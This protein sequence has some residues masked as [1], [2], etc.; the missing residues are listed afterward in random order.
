MTHA[1][2]REA[3]RDRGRERGKDETMTPSNH[4]HKNRPT[5]SDRTQQLYNYNPPFY[6][7]T[8]SSP[9]YSSFPKIRIFSSIPQK[10]HHSCFSSIHP[11][12]TQHIPNHTPLLKKLTPT[13]ILKTDLSILPYSS[14]HVSRRPTTST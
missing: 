5:L 9:K 3:A 8:P 6:S 4:H 14:M 11:P 10:Q 13:N 12:A 1:G 7:L 2:K